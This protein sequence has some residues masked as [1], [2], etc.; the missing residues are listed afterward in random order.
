MRSLCCL[1]LVLS[2]EPRPFLTHGEWV[3]SALTFVY[4]LLTG[5]YAWTSHKTLTA[6]EDQGRHAKEESEAR[7]REFAQQ[8]KVSQDT[9]A[10]ALQSSQT[11]INA[12]RAWILVKFEV[13]GQAPRNAHIHFQGKNWGRTPAEI[14]RCSVTYLPYANESE[15]PEEA[16]YHKTELKYPKHVA[17]SESFPI[18]DG[19]SL[20]DMEFTDELWEDMNKKDQRL[21]FIGHVVYKDLISRADHETRFCFFL[22]RQPGVG[23]IMTG[24]RHYNQHT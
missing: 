3:M 5:F 2:Q 24:P 12:E 18:G 15:L 10:A 9:A 17:P 4:V 7:D 11:A 23:L 20:L 21:F 16:P 6:L 22:S 19:P 8:L 1:S 14:S 13:T